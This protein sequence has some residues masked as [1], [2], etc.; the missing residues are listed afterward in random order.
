MQSL[1]FIMFI[2][3]EKIAKFMFLP[4]TDTRQAGQLACLTL[5]ITQIH[6]FHVS[7]KAQTFI[8]WIIYFSPN[9]K[10]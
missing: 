10:A 5:I 7:Q 6:I 9:M 1:T 8:T 3:S 2:V 4:H